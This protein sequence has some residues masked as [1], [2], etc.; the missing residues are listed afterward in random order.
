[1]P[2]SVSKTWA[3]RRRSFPEGGEGKLLLSG[4]ND[5][6]VKL[7]E[8]T[9]DL[10]AGSLFRE[11][12]GLD[13]GGGGGWCVEHGQKVNCVAAPGNLD[14]VFVAGVSKTVS[15]YSVR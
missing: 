2:I 6:K 5:G 8:W 12:E 4:G 15:V 14:R 11:G 10:P 3:V 1:M 7:Q 9:R 13:G